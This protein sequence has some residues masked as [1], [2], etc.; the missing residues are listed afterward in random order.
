MKYL[1][2]SFSCLF[3]CAFVQAQCTDVYASATYGMSHS[4]RALKADNADHQAYYAERALKALK[5]SQELNKACG[6]TNAEDPTYNG[7]DNLLKASDP[8]DWDMGRYYTQRA[9]A[10]IEQLLTALDHCSNEGSDSAEI[11]ESSPADTQKSEEEWKEQ[12]AIREQAENSLDAMQRSIAEISGLIGCD[13]AIEV[14]KKR[15]SRSLDELK[16]E[17]VAETL[18]FYKELLQQLQKDSAT[19]LAACT[20]SP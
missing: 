8:K 1:L 15:T 17:T 16:A 9:I 3:T 18:D 7:I 6:C 13:S 20:P 5:K 2:L 19:S 11:P 4:K 12:L 10:E 14:F